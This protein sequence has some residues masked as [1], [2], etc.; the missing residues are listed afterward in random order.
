MS[1]IE[2]LPY[3]NFKKENL[4]MI[5]HTAMIVPDYFNCVLSLLGIYR[6]YHGIEIQHP[7]NAMMLLNLI[8]A[9]L[10]TQT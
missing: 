4:I 5:V 3:I 2:D 8:I 1:I 6:M 10:F 7:L 9:F